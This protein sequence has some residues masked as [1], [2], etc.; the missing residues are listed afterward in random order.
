M[1]TALIT[2]AAVLVFLALFFLVQATHTPT[3]QD[4][5]GGG[6]YGCQ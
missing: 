3:C 5:N 1:K 2:I 6:G 4:L